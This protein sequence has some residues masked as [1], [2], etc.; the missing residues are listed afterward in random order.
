MPIR[1]RYTA[2]RRRPGAR[3]VTTR[4][5]KA[6]Q[7]RGT[8]VA[9]PMA[10]LGMGFPKKLII[11]HKYND[12]ITMTSISGETKNYVYLTNGLYDPNSTGGGHQPMGFDN[13]AALYDRYTVIGAQIE[14]L[15]LQSP[16][17]TINGTFGLF[18][19]NSATWNGQSPYDQGEQNQTAKYS[20][21]SNV[22]IKPLKFLMRW[23]AKK[24]FGGT[25]MSNTALSG[26]PTNNPVTSQYF[27]MTYQ[28]F[29]QASAGSVQVGVKI[30]YIAIWSNLKEQ[31]EQ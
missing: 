18:I 8:T 29:D 23:S 10:K 30:K 12:Q 11:T 6:A 22:Q 19:D 3:P 21:I 14:L 7:R 4:R 15:V 27:S 16:T 5:R 28:P 25:V 31:A 1:R 17:T 24:N 26:G 20:I 9:R 2:I 13:L